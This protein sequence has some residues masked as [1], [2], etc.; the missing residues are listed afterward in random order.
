MAAHQSWGYLRPYRFPLS[1][2]A[3]LTLVET[4]LFLARPWPLSLAVDSAVDHRPLPAWLPELSPHAIAAAAGLASVVL[5]ALQG[6]VAYAQ[7]VL[8]ESATARV[9]GDLR[10]EVLQ[11]LLQLGPRFH[12]RHR[13]GEL[14]SR[15]TSDVRRVQDAMVVWF[16]VAIPETLLLIG[17]LVVLVAVDPLLAATA[18]GVLPLL[19]LA[20]VVRRA[21]V[22]AAERS[23]REEAGR[24]AGQATELLRNIRSVQAFA[25]EQRSGAEFRRQNDRATRRTLQVIGIEARL[26]PISELLLAAGGGLVLWLGVLAV[27]DGRLSVGALLVVLSYLSSVY[28]PVRRL[29]RMGSTLAMGSASRDRLVEVLGSDAVVPQRRMPVLL[30][31]RPLVLTFD[32][33]TFGY[34]PGQPVLRDVSL[35]VR[36]GEMVAVVGASGAGKSTLLSLVQRFGDPDIGAIRTGG[37]DVRATELSAL[38]RRIAIVPQEPWLVDGSIAENIAF[39][40]PD[41]S[42]EAIRAAAEAAMV[43]EFADRLP[44]GLH[45]PVGEGGLMLSGGQRKRIALARGVLINADI[46]L[47]DEPTSGL[48][49]HSSAL[50]IDALR[51]AGWGR[52]V[53]LVTHQMPL[54]AVADRIV[55]LDEGRV[56]EQ[57]A[58]ATLLDQNG[59]YTRLCGTPAAGD[60]LIE[61]SFTA[62]GERR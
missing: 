30:P 20:V 43:C 52:T 41:A 3:L 23:S 44:L 35:T 16:T 29:T 25:R 31:P 11:R 19:G 27:L 58:H 18:A 59:A 57:G 51:Q 46:L 5:V 42:D 21:R 37:V 53:L 22:R 10:Q 40:R 36:P 48:D 33:V 54:A 34:V 45:A 12:E 2:A 1:G 61:E 4:A 14:V 32:H 24:L 62:V 7:V 50:V 8:S 60:G 6:V 56:V 39:G 28:G 9:G 15:L 13:T 17:M 47:L 38:R 26:Y 49:P 55:V